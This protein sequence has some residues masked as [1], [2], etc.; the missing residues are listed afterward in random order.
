MLLGGSFRFRTSSDCE[1]V[2]NDVVAFRMHSNCST[3]ASVSREGSRA[4]SVCSRHLSPGSRL[5]EC[6]EC[7][8]PSV[9]SRHLSP[10]L[11]RLSGVDSGDQNLC[12]ICLEEPKLPVQGGCGHTACF[13]CIWE[14]LHKKPECPSCLQPLH[15]RELRNLRSDTINI[16]E[17][18]Q[19]LRFRSDHFRSSASGAPGS[20]ETHSQHEARVD[21]NAAAQPAVLRRR[22]RS[23]DMTTDLPLHHRRP[24]R[25]WSSSRHRVEAAAAAPGALPRYQGALMRPGRGEPVGMAA[26]PSHRAAQGRSPDPSARRAASTRTRSG[27]PTAGALDMPQ[28]PPQHPQRPRVNAPQNHSTAGS[29]PRY[30]PSNMPAAGTHTQHRS[31]TPTRSKAPPSYQLATAA[32]TASSP[33]LSG[34]WTNEGVAPRR[35]PS[36]IRSS[37]ARSASSGDRLSSDSP[38]VSDESSTSGSKSSSGVGLLQRDPHTSLSPHAQGGQLVRPRRPS[39]EPSHGRPPVASVVQ[40]PSTS[41][42]QAWQ[43]STLVAAAP[44]TQSFDKATRPT[45]HMAS[46]PSYGPSYVPARASHAIAAHAPSSQA[47]SHAT[48]SFLHSQP[49]WHPVQQGPTSGWSIAAAPTY[50]RTEQQPPPPTAYRQPTMY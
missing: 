16:E 8:A 2:L 49:S 43:Q 12:P 31:I 21:Q 45:L 1:V 44:T 29:P 11:S 4:P 47:A 38:G 41:V 7:R 22:S 39:W 9:S 28:R 35:R 34:A 5:S 3:P 46:G 14:W 36:V 48:P 17:Y 32:P 15:I 19:Q 50:T 33:L 42:V 26:F 37:S 13:Q 10:S 24:P 20:P 6:G 25:S 27:L 30:S 23:R 18:R 40:R